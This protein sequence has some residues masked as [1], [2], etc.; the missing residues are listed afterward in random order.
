MWVPFV[1]GAALLVVVHLVGNA[2]ID[3]S[4][5]DSASP[6][7]DG[8][9]KSTVPQNY[10]ANGTEFVM[11]ADIQSWVA[12]FVIGEPV[13]SMSGATITASEMDGYPDI[14]QLCITFNVADTH[15]GVV[16]PNHHMTTVPIDV[17][18]TRQKTHLFI[19]TALRQAWLHELAESITIDGIRPY[20]PH[21][22]DEW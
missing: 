17:L 8:H 19:W 13:K 4:T 5:E 2:L 12:D 6:T 18:S 16:Q 1:F 10:D 20:D 22:Q 9:A 11:L 14:V 3:A 15:T 21:K 7:A